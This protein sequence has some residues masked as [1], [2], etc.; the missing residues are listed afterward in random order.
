MIIK[1]YFLILL[2]FLYKDNVTLCSTYS[3]GMSAHYDHGVFLSSIILRRELFFFY[4]LSTSY[5][6]SSHLCTLR[7][8]EKTRIVK[9][10]S[11][12]RRMTSE[13]TD[14]FIA[15]TFLFKCKV[16]FCSYVHLNAIIKLYFLKKKI[17]SK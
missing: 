2:A 11:Y 16:M 1:Y 7:T 3:Q 13:C 5:L 9:L 12:I 14:F 8:R 15:S 4:Y 10:L 17:L 6:P